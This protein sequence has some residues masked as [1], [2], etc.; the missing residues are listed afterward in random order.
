M[1]MT[2]E[3]DLFTMANLSPLFTGLPFVVWISPRNAP[4]DIRVKI[5]RGP[6]AIDPKGPSEVHL[7]TAVAVSIPEHLISVAL[8]PTLRVI[9]DETLTS[10]E[11]A[12]LKQWVDLNWET[13]LAYWDGAIFTENAIAALRP[14][15][16]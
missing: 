3:D 15:A 10:S 8:R 9:G 2:T 4:H 11:L 14:I 6:K 12:L 13:L 5:S 16:E 1:T 7:P